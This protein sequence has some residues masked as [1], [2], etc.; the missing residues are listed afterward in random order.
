MAKKNKQAKELAKIKKENSPKVVQIIMLWVLIPLLFLAAVL[1]IIAKFADIN[2]FDEAKEL[3]KKLPFTSE[4][5]EEGDGADNL[6]LEDSVV[7][8][9]A[10]IQEKE[11][12]LFKLQKDLDTSA[13]EKDKLLIEQER[14]L[15]EID[16]LVREKD[17]FKRKFSEIVSTFEKMSAKTAAPVLTKMNDAEALQLLTNMKP[18]TLAAILEKMSPEDAAKYTTMM[19]K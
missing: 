18:D 13:A 10:E 8:L 3:T 5:K 16:K 12:Q 7:T 6:V 14:L 17:D 19:T 9:Q 4:K 1:L 2:V 11:A 15:D